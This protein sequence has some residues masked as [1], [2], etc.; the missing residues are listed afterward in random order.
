MKKHTLRALIASFVLVSCTSEQAWCT[1]N[2]PHVPSNQ[3]QGSLRSPQVIND[4]Q[5]AGL[6]SGFSSTTAH[7]PTALSTVSD[8]NGGF[9]AN[10]ITQQASSVNITAT[11]LNG[12]IS[13]ESFSAMSSGLAYGFSEDRSPVSASVNLNTEGHLSNTNSLQSASMDSYADV[14]K[15]TG[16][17]QVFNTG[18]ITSVGNGTTFTN[19][20][21]LSSSAM[22][23][24][25]GFRNAATNVSSNINF[26]SL[27]N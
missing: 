7:N 15:G 3:E 12:L 17:S 20:V 16:W 11:G 14:T 23:V 2:N 5:I 9:L 19:N 6:A 25:S 21:D 10:S 18:Q 26:S 4:P 13:T 22:S 27:M 1:T 24:A 8:G